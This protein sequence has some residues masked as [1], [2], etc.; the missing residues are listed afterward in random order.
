MQ[1]GNHLQLPQLAA[2]ASLAREFRTTCHAWLPAPCR[3][4]RLWA[5]A[6]PFAATLN[7]LPIME[8]VLLSFELPMRGVHRARARGL[9]WAPSNRDWRRVPNESYTPDVARF[10]QRLR[11][12][13]IRGFE[14]DGDYLE[15]DA[16]A[17]DDEDMHNALGRRLSLLHEAV[18]ASVEG[19]PGCVLYLEIGY[20]NTHDEWDHG[21]EIFARLSFSADGG[22]L[23]E[24]CLQG[25]G[26]LNGE[27][28][29][30]DRGDYSIFNPKCW[31]DSNQSGLRRVT[32]QTNRQAFASRFAVNDPLRTCDMH[33]TLIAFLHYS[34]DV[35]T[36]G[37]RDYG[38]WVPIT[39][40]WQ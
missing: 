9:E 24:L 37:G 21:E 18:S 27:P 2:F 19:A 3:Q 22:E 10:V 34:F 32:Q 38:S 23:R 13:M 31:Y 39:V 30:E 12:R 1:I 33:Q 5:L 35:F 15:G 8:R 26:D 7:G 11:P 14:A 36:R 4:E 40:P 6:D 28:L 25:Q 20:F 29:V 16:R 17:L